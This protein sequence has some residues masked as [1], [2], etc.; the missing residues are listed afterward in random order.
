MGEAFDIGGGNAPRSGWRD[1]VHCHREDA[2][3]EREA[4]VAHGVG[5]DD[6][7]IVK[8]P[9]GSDLSDTLVIQDHGAKIYS[10]GVVSESG[11]G[12]GALAGEDEGIFADLRAS[13]GERKWHT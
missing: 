11:L 7:N 10:V 13:G 12:G 3:L 5:D 6:E 2:R 9:V 4:R 8:A 1:H